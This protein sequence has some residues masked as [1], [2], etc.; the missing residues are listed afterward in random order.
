MQKKKTYVYFDGHNFFRHY[1]K[2]KPMGCKWLDLQAFME[3]LMGDE[4]NIQKIYY[5]TAD[6][7]PFPDAPDRYGNQQAYIRAL[8]TLDTVHIKRGK[9][10]NRKTYLPILGQSPQRAQ[11]RSIREKQTDT[12]LVTKIF[13]DAWEE[14]FDSAV[15]VSNDSDFVACVIALRRLSDKEIG[16]ALNRD[17]ANQFRDHAS[18]IKGIYPVMIRGSQFAPTLPGRRKPIHK[19]LGW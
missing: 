13:E 8:E 18:F 2:G 5:F 10:Q 9:F 3:N 16:V 17:E 1:L 14:K 6:V 7:L 19:P 4:Y 12:K 11:V 15:I